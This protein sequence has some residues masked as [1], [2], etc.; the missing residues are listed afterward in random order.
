MEDQLIQ[1]ETAKLAK[2]KGFN[3]CSNN[4]KG[5]NKN[6]GTLEM[7]SYSTYVN[8]EDFEITGFYSASTQSLLQRWLREVHKIDVIPTMSEFSRTYGYKL[9]YIEGGKTVCSNHMF[10]KK[11]IYEEVL[12]QGLIEALKLIKS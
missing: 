3:W 6:D 11:E 12:E 10:I 8:N 9:F 5:Y 7:T 2:E 1:F 4:Q